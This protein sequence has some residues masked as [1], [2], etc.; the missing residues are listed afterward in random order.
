MFAFDLKALPLNVSESGIVKTQGHT[1]A[2]AV[3]KVKKGAKMKRINI[4]C[5]RGTCRRRVAQER[6]SSSIECKWSTGRV[7]EKEELGRALM[8]KTAEE[9]VVAVTMTTVPKIFNQAHAKDEDE[10]QF[11]KDTSSSLQQSQ[12]H[13]LTNGTGELQVLHIREQ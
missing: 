6:F 3:M 13:R 4:Y 11:P 2:R 8:S 9:A 12:G 5:L 10:C 1:G 7:D